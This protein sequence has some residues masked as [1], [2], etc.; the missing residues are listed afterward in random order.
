[1]ICLIFQVQRV[2]PEFKGIRETQE[3][4]L[5]PKVSGEHRGTQVS[6]ELPVQLELR[7]S[8]GTQVSRVSQDP[9]EPLV[10]LDHRVSKVSRVPPAI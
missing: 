7:V 6:K 8:R 1:M 2:Q 10:L 3:V 9:K 4:L 5:V